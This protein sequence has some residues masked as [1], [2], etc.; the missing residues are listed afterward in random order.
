MSTESE[1]A[2]AALDT[3][4]GARELPPAEAAAKLRDF[5]NSISSPIPDSSRLAH[6]ASALKNL[7]SELATAGSASDDDWQSAIETMLSL[8]NENS[9]SGS[10]DI[11]RCASLACRGSG[12]RPSA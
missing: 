11:E 8:A 6:A 1:L 7:V 5:L 12:E 4:R 2:T 10:S 3:L 9:C